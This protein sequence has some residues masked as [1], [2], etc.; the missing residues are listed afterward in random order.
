MSVVPRRFVNL[1]VIG[2]RC[3]SGACPTI[4]ESDPA[5]QSD[6]RTV[7]VQGFAVSPRDAG[8]DLPEGELLV[9]IPRSLLEEAARNLS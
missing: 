4:Y 2:N 6:A 5:D 7:V 8:I 1:R 3:A 9:E